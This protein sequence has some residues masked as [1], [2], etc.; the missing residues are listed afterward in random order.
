[1]VEGVEVAAG[2]FEGLD[3]ALGLGGGGGALAYRSCRMRV[4]EV[5]RGGGANTSAIIMWQSNVPFP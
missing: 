3:P 1:V 2:V 5:E 4:G